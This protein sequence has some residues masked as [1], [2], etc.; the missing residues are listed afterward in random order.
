MRWADDARRL[1]Q[2]DEAA[3]W[4]AGAERPTPPSLHVTKCLHRTPPALDCRRADRTGPARGC[5]QPG[6]CPPGQAPRPRCSRLQVPR[7][8]VAP[9]NVHAISSRFR[10]LASA[11]RASELGLPLGWRRRRSAGTTRIEHASRG[12]W[13][14]KVRRSPSTTRN[15]NVSD[16]RHAA[17]FWFDMV[18]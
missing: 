7:P 18:P 17:R 14:P 6:A 9:A 11:A 3:S 12:G 10:A 8:D 15:G 4:S 2:R 5:G 16:E 1:T 13:S